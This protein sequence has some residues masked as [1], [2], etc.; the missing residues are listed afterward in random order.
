M[1]CSIMTRVSSAGSDVSSAWMSTRSA[2]ES[3]AAGSSSSST[4]GLSARASSTS[5]SRTSPWDRSEAGAA[6]RCASPKLAAR[7]AA[8]AIL[9]R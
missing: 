6:S 7:S 9:A 2:A 8:S 5:S 3:P 1:S 4:L